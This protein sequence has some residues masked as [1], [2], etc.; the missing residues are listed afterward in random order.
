[1]I[2]VNALVNIAEFAGAVADRAEHPGLL[3]KAVIPNR[4]G[5]LRNGERI[6][7]VCD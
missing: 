7:D 1:M 2:I 3:S 4:T 6:S 5:W